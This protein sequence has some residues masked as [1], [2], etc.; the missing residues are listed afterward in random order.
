[1]HLIGSGESLQC[2]GTH[3]HSLYA[4][5]SVGYIEQLDNIDA[6]SA[7]WV[8][9]NSVARNWPGPSCIRRKI[10]AQAIIGNQERG[11]AQTCADIL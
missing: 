11:L 9:A 7:R 5:W 6:R 10:A 2:M 8:L 3:L 4:I 1:M